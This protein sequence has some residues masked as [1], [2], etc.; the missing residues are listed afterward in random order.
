M[1]ARRVLAV[2]DEAV[3]LTLVAR[4]LT[5]HGFEVHTATRAVD[6]IAKVEEI[7]PDLVLVDVDLGPGPDGMQLARRIAVSN[8]STVIV[9]LT[10]FP[11]PGSLMA[12]RLPLPNGGYVLRKSSLESPEKLAEALDRFLRGRVVA[13]RPPAASPLAGLTRVQVDVLRLAAAGLANSAIAE[14]RGVTLRAVEHALQAV[15]ARLGLV[16]GDGVNARVDAVR[17]YLDAAG[18]VDLD[19]PFWRSGAGRMSA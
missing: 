19:E 1:V 9:F 11:D 6:A 5:E 13:E 7:D 8:P 2:D 10:R 16:D 12:R 4:L 15:Y 14:A 3:S 17:R 18:P